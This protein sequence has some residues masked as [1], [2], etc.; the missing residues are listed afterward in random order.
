MSY[1]PEH[2][3]IREFARRTLANIECINSGH[4]IKWEDTVLIC[5]LLAVFVVPQDRRDPRAGDFMADLV[6]SSRD[7]F[8]EVFRV[9]RSSKRDI[10]GAGLPNNIHELPRYLRNAVA[11]FN[12]KPISQD[13]HSLTHLLVW[14]C[15]PR[16]DSKN[17]GKLTFVAR[18]DVQKLTDLAKHILEK[19]KS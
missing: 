8:A 3:F 18:V 13:G 1:Y 5:F 11:H 7:K 19:L 2:T 10:D 9:E 6:S 17:A 12:V 16:S 4:P 14:N 15:L